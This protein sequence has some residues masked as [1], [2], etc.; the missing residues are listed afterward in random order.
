MLEFHLIFSSQRC[1]YNLY[2]DL[3][4]LAL[5]WVYMCALIPGDSLQTVSISEFNII[6][7]PYGKQTRRSAV[8]VV[9]PPNAFS[10]HSIFWL[11]GFLVSSSCVTVNIY[12]IHHYRWMSAQHIHVYFSHSPSSVQQTVK[13]VLT[14][15]TRS[16]LFVLHTLCF[17]T[18]YT[19]TIDN[20]R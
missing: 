20:N 6:S 7:C 5:S 9:P 16:R 4:F 19:V 12:V 15:L 10:F 13:S 1:R 14:Y 17:F 3:Y 8:P 11:G 2:L 18:C